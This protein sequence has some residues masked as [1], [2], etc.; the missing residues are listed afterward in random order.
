MA[1]TRPP[2]LSAAS[3][4]DQRVISAPST[5]TT[6]TDTSYVISIAS[7]ASSFAAAASA[8]DNRIHLFDKSNLRPLRTFQGHATSITSMRAVDA[9]RLISSGKDGRVVVWDDRKPDGVGAQ[10]SAGRSLLCCDVSP[11][12]T[13]IAAGS[14]LEGEDAVIFYWDTRQNS[15][16]IRT[17]SSTHS[18]DVTVVRFHPTQNSSDPR[19]LLSA[20]SD[21]LLSIS[22]VDEDDEDEAVLH[23]ANWG[24]SIAQAGWIPSRN[25]RNGPSVWASSDMETFSTWSNELDS[26]HSTDIREPAIHGA[27]RTW[28]TDYLVGCV[29]ASG[30]CGDE[31]SL[32]IYLGSNEG[33]VALTTCNTQ[34]P[35]WTLRR[36]WTHGHAGVVRSVL[37]DDERHVLLT[38][39]E[40]GKL[41][42]W[43][44]TQAGYGMDI[45]SSN[46]RGTPQ[47]K[48]ELEH[49]VRLSNDAMDISD[50]SE[51]MQQGKRARWQ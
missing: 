14:D 26:L 35:D 38:G 19:L 7:L 8:P 25:G 18:D 40:D 20:S 28:V 11:D 42:L 12:A 44:D 33:D 39:G 29:P 13:A 47:R 45:D 48:R 22:N 10:F 50:P 43:P 3:D 9:Q 2:S 30:D 36:L 4:L 32:G 24:C 5:S 27:K 49:E 46:S 51:G 16:P 34:S 23:V 1:S 31:M 17:H 6:L 15:V 37:Y 21:G 41:C